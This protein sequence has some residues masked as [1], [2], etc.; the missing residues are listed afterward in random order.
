MSKKGQETTSSFTDMEI[1]TYKYSVFPGSN[2]GSGTGTFGLQGKSSST[3][4]HGLLNKVMKKLIIE[5]V[6]N[7]EFWTYDTLGNIS[8][9]TIV[10]WIII[11]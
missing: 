1:F 5:L 3:E 7:I 6:L 8:R 9:P 10:H 2:L 11:K 4:L